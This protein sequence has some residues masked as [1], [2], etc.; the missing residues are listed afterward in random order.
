M[1]AKVCTCGWVGVI[2]VV[3]IAC[4]SARGTEDSII[5]LDDFDSYPAGANLSGGG[6]GGWMGRWGGN[7]TVSPEESVS[8]P[9]SAKM[10]NNLGCWESLLY[11]SLPSHPVTWF[12][13]DIMGKAT[14][15][16]G[17]HQYDV[18]I[19]LVNP[20]EGGPFGCSL[21]GI[22]LVVCQL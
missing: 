17:C 15:R 13:A 5:L 1:R 10:D 19:C 3:V 8:L 4:S 11:H 21:V 12:S 14:G 16:T 6:F 2:L 7:I 22:S 9:H 20:D 18:H